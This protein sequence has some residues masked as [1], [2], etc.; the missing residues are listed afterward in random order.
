MNSPVFDSKPGETGASSWPAEMVFAQTCIESK[1]QDLL[2]CL[3]LGY[4]ARQ[5]FQIRFH[6]RLA[7]RPMLF[8]DFMRASG[9]PPPAAKRNDSAA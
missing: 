6:N 9:S 2:I 3:A 8:G 5:T 4:Q 1:V 7:T